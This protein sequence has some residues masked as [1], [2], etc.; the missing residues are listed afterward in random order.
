MFNFT[1]NLCFVKL[2]HT[3]YQ[4]D[5]WIIPTFNR[6]CKLLDIIFEHEDEMVP[7][8]FKL[9]TQEEDEEDDYE[10]SPDTL[11]SLRKLGQLSAEAAK[12]KAMKVNLRVITLYTFFWNVHL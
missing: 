12:L 3:L 10:P 9:S 5:K 11:L 1:Y 7:D 6:F 4:R 8:G 2:Y